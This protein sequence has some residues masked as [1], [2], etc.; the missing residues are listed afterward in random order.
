[1]KKMIVFLM[2]LLL[3][4]NVAFATTQRGGPH[5]TLQTHLGEHDVPPQE[6]QVPPQGVQVPPE[7]FYGKLIP[8]LA[9]ILFLWL[10]KP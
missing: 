6:V 9:G 4:T 8:I 10:I 1:M 7:P 3:F 2:C 5:L